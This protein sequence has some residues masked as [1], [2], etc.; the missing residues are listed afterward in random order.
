MLELLNYRVLLTAAMEG[1]LP[2]PAGGW[3]TSAP[4]K[5]TGC[6]N[7]SGL[8]RQV[9]GQSVG[10]KQKRLFSL[11]G[12]Q[13]FLPALWE[14]DVIY[15]TQLDVDLQTQVGEGLRSRLLN[16]LHLHTLRRHAKYCVANT[17]HLRCG[18]GQTYEE[19]IH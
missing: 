12:C 13:G 2:S 5:I 7:T 9:K 11:D 15:P 14:E 19:A 4:R 1:F 3:V 10:T 17:F 8:W 6:W 16:I 18:A